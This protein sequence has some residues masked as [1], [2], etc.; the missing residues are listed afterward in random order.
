MI[1]AM[2]KLR[3]PKPA[4]PSGSFRELTQE[5]PTAKD[6]ADIVNPEDGIDACAERRDG[7]YLKPAAMDRS[8]FAN[9]NRIG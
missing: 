3:R 5:Q 6:Q 1:Q 9:D 4:V 2:K 8:W 7:C